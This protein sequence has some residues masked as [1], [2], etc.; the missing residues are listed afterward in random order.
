[1]QTRTPDAV[2]SRTNAALRGRA[3]VGL[4]AALPARRAGPGCRS[5]RRA[6]TGSARWR[7]A[8]RPC[9]CCRC[10]ALD[11]GPGAARPAD[12]AGG[13]R[14]TPRP[15]ARRTGGGARGA[16]VDRGVHVGRGARGRVRAA[17]TGAPS[18]GR[19]G[20]RAFT[21]N[22]R[23]GLGSRAWP[24]H[25][26]RSWWAAVTTG[27]IAA[28]YLA[29]KGAR[30][31]VLEAR[32]KTGGAADTMSPVAR[33][34]RDQGHDASYVMSLMPD[35]ILRD[36]ELARHGYRD[37]PDRPV[38]RAVPR[39]AAH[40]PV[41]RRRVGELRRVREVLQARRRR[42]R[43]VG[44]VDRRPRRRARPAADDDA[45]ADG[46]AVD[47]R[48]HRAAAARVAVPRAQGA[49]RRRRHA[50]DDDVDRG[51]PRPVLRV[52]P[53]EDRD[54]AQRPDRDLGGTARARDRLR[55][56][57]PLD[58]RRRR[59]PRRR[60]GDRDR[61]DGR[62]GRGPRVERAVVRRRDPDRGAGRADPHRGRRRPRRGARGRRG[63][64][65]AGRRRGDPPRDHVPAPAR[66]ER[67]PAC[68]RRR[69]PELAVAL[70]HGED[71]PGARPRARVLVQAGPWRT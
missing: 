11:H 39:R 32:H 48:P 29:K 47:A 55:D 21:L 28:A 54:G 67:A 56:G 60:V 69:H 50:A 38:L 71:Q 61:R 30:T 7:R 34:A 59:R 24:P 6:R 12:G 45:A 3:V 4:A 33:G 49:G 70:G 68:V 41:R 52:R 36:L 63:A 44:R 14:P 57:A 42:D 20:A 25:T 2:R 10:A 65:G 26:T 31:V 62:G 15:R 16:G 58:R 27:L 66:G 40:R 43:A 19:A 51:H 13:P 46:V 64:A 17:A 1:M 53:G 8:S 9:G 18:P 37:G 35:T 23:S 22:R 5:R